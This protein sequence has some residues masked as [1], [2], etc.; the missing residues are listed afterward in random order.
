MCYGL[1]IGLAFVLLCTSFVAIIDLL[2]KNAII[3]TNDPN[4]S[5][6][7]SGNI[8]NGFACCHIM[9]VFLIFFLTNFL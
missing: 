7:V 6:L 1:Y 3:A 9:F 4:Y 5:S 2:Y 8:N